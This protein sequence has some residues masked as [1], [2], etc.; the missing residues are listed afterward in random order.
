L[1]L[2]RRFSEGLLL[3]VSYT[4]GKAIN[5]T[6][7][8]SGGLMWNLPELLSRNRAV[9]GYDRTHNFRAAYVW[10]LPFGAGRRWATSDRILKALFGGWQING[11]FSSYSG[12]PFS[13]SASGT[14]LNAPGNSQTAD[15]VKPDVQRPGGIGPGQ[16]YFDPTAFAQVLQTRFGNSG[17]NILRGPGIVNL[18]LSLF[19]NFRLGERWNLQFRAESFNLTNTPKFANPNAAVESTAFMTVNSTVGSDSNLEGAS[20]GF[21]FGLR[22][23]F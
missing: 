1:R 15:Q 2:D 8:S 9:A 5:Y 22:L 10:D 3:K 12:T 17:R 11:I 13:V 18:D 21:R 7:D 6:D 19:R 4:F 23:N 16:H 14:A 20:R